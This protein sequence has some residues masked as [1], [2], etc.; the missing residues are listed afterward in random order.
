MQIENLPIDAI[1]PNPANVRMHSAEQLRL[2]EASIRR[3][4]FREPCVVNRRDDG[5]ISCEAGHA[6]LEAARAAG[7]THVDCVVCDD[8]ELT[9]AAYGIASN[10]LAELASW[11]SAG[12]LA[13]L[14]ALDVQG[15]LDDAVGWAQPELDRL[16][17]E[18]AG[19]SEEDWQN[20]L[21]K[22]PD[23]EKS[24]FQQ[25]TFTLHDSQAETVQAALSVAKGKGL[26]ADPFNENSNGCALTVICDRYLAEVGNGRG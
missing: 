12:L 17:A 11:D 6:R 2:L 22:L 1:L 7:L 3:F 5:T 8:D 13:Q 26:A 19:P 10:R 20:A 16:R 15:A 14:D 25:M 21:G 4:G 24:P 23:G 9:A 18:V